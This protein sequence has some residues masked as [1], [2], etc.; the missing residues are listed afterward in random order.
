M[1]S[2]WGVSNSTVALL[3]SL[4]AGGVTTAGLLLI[5][6]Y[7]DLAQRYSLYLVGFAAGILNTI[8]LVHLLPHSLEM[9]S[10][11]PWLWLSG[12]LLLYL[13][14]RFLEHRLLGD[15]TRGRGIIA[16]LGIGYHSFVDGIIYVVTFNV[17]IF[18]GL[19]SAL[20]MV[21]HEFPEGV[22]TFALLQEAGFEQKRA[23]FYAFL[24]AALTTPLGALVAYPWIEVIDQETLGMLLA[25]AGGALLFVGTTHLLPRLATAR[26]RVTLPAL[27]AGTVV[28]LL[29]IQLGH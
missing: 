19:L 7:K 16:L 5:S 21:L 28:G 10:Y 11:A 1:T 2:V 25:L 4:V 14:D 13:S 18:T 12:F 8:S 3:A 17:S 20:G 15:E 26:R 27:L 6:R 24:A 9:V 23:I 22:V 29:V